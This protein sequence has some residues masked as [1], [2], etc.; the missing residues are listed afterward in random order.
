MPSYRSM[1]ALASLIIWDAHTCSHT[2]YGSIFYKCD[3]S[4]LQ[5]EVAISIR[6]VK[7]KITIRFSL[8]NE[9][10]KCE[11]KSYLDERENEN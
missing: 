10:E 11:T 7:G 2:H 4:L 3:H 5:L 1:I 8:K 6:G 9:I